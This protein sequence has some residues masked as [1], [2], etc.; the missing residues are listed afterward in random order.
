MVVVVLAFAP[1]LALRRP[2]CVR[3]RTDANAGRLRGA[4]SLSH[5]DRA[6]RG[7]QSVL[8]H[9]VLDCLCVQQA[10]AAAAAKDSHTH[11]SNLF[12][13]ATHPPSRQDLLF[14]P[15]LRF[16]RY[17]AASQRG[18]P[19]F[20]IPIYHHR[21]ARELSFFG[22]SALFYLLGSDWLMIGHC[23]GVLGV[24]GRVTVHG[25]YRRSGVFSGKGWDAYIHICMHVCI[26]SMHIKATSCCYHHHGGGSIQFP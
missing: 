13:L 10:A 14:G 20:I 1:E 16:S 7:S 18:H 15:I 21:F 19:F 26:V 12:T 23:L 9:V 11:Q 22:V 5:P 24:S 25:T 6:A 4:S 17:P 2:A 3:L 8:L